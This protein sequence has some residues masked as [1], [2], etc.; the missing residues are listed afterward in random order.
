M[1]ARSATLGFVADLY[2]DPV[3]EASD[4]GIAGGAVSSSTTCSVPAP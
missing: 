2:L 3:T 1:R 4:P